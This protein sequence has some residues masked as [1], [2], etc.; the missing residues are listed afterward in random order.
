MRLE[1]QLPTLAPQLRLLAATAAPREACGVI[2]RAGRII[3]FPNRAAQAHEEFAAGALHELEERA[4]ELLAIFHTHPDNETPSPAD[5]AHCDASFLPWVVAGPRDLFVLHPEPRPYVQREFVYGVED[6]WQL[7]SDWHAQEAGLFLP[8]FERPA[9]GWWKTAGPSPYLEHAAAY[10][11][12]AA[13][14]CEWGLE[15][16]RLGDVILMQLAARRTNHAAIY[17]G[18]GCL[19]HHLYGELSRIE[20]FSGRMQSS[21]THIARHQQLARTFLVPNP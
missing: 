1:S 4:G 8:W 14:L 6:C 9:D 18:G 5:V 16:L 2:T 17:V 21:T 10:G 15:N 20:T 19:L 13:P 3:R 7:V 12:T 11:F